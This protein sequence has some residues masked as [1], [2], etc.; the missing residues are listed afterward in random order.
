MAIAN[1]SIVRVSFSLTVR[2]MC[3]ARSKTIQK[4]RIRKM[5]SLN[6]FLNTSPSVSPLFSV[7]IKEKSRKDEVEGEP[8]IATDTIINPT[9]VDLQI[10]VRNQAYKVVNHLQEMR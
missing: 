6:K 8:G 4:K 9:G 7:P 1:I 10:K 2:K 3:I 5:G